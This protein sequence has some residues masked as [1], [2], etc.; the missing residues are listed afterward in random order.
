MTFRRQNGGWLQLEERPTRSGG[1]ISFWYDVSERIEAQTQVA[2]LQERLS[3]A[4]ESLQDGFALF[5]MQKKFR[6][7][8]DQSYS[9]R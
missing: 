4:V 7:C 8:P 2:T 6:F 1:L 9:I 3:D 5:E